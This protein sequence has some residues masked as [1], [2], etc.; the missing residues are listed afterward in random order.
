MVGDSIEGDAILGEAK[1]SAIDAVP[2]HLVVVSNRLGNIRDLSQ[3]GGL[4]VGVADALADRGGLWLGASALYQDSA[5]SD[6]PLIQLERVGRIETAALTL[7]REE[8][9][10][11]Y[12]GYANSTL[13][14]LFHYRLDLV[15]HRG[16]YLHAY[17]QINARFAKALA[18]L[19]LGND[20]LVWVHDYHL[21]PLAAELRRLG[22]RNRIGFFLHIPFPPPDLFAAAPDHEELIDD[23]LEDDVLGFQTETDVMNFRRSVQATSPTTFDINGAAEANGRTVLSRCFPIGIDVD[24]FARM[25]NEA[26]EDVQIDSMRR[27]I[28]GLKQII[29]VDRLDYSKGLPGRMQAFAR[30]LERHPEHERAVTYLQIASPTREEVSAYADIR[31][32]LEATSGSVNGRYADLAWTP[33]RYIHRAVPRSRLAGLLRAS[34]VGLVT[35]L[36]DGMNLVAK[37]YIAAQDQANPGVL[38]LSRFAGAAEE[39]AESLIVNPYVID[40]VADAIASALAMPL[41]ERIARH[42]A[43]LKRIRRN[44]AAKWR[45]SF[46]ATLADE[47]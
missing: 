20:D 33:I 42:G 28:L 24:S 10:L 21:I 34:Q 25:A 14:P 9:S 43:L 13:W 37:E 41:D 26:A 23:L 38:V 12:N 36:R 40:E 39:L 15:N 11:Y 22:F 46:L 4:A 16:E 6:E 7:P 45:R 1:Q 2:R 32:Q 5:A 47:D 30:L 31:A 19:H 8:Y 29:G 27:Q 35:P 3:A 18:A 17:R 44:D